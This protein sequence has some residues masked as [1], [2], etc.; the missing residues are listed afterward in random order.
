MK[1]L[2]MIIIWFLKS[3][4][5]FL[6]NLKLLIR[7]KIRKLLELSKYNLLIFKAT[8]FKKCLKKNSNLTE[9][10]EKKNSSKQQIKNF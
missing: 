7:L 1:N 5:L 4:D 2:Q 6:P 9:R 3:I 10:F 8:M